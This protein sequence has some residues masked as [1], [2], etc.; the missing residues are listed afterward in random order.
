MVSMGDDQDQQEELVTD[1]QT[2]TK[3]GGIYTNLANYFETDIR[4]QQI[5]LIVDED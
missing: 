1:D 5:D 4:G 3:L 2:E